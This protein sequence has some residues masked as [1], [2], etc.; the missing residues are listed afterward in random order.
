M[1]VIESFNRPWRACIP[2]AEVNNIHN[3]I[4]Q[5]RTTWITQPQNCWHVPRQHLDT[6]GKSCFL[7]LLAIFWIELLPSLSTILI[8]GLELYI[9]P[10]SHRDCTGTDS[11]WHTCTWLFRLISSPTPGH[12]F[13]CKRHENPS[14]RMGIE[15]NYYE[16]KYRI[17]GSIENL[18]VFCDDLNLQVDGKVPRDGAHPHFPFHLPFWWQLCELQANRYFH[19]YS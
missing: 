18:C 5:H 10:P 9:R 12:D 4:L 15:I 1:K 14:G 3:S 11:C 16:D 17:F 8:L 19:T 2:M 7:F 13:H 6:H